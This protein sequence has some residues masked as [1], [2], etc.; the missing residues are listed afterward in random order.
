[1]CKREIRDEEVTFWGK[2]SLVCGIQ[3][4]EEDL[5]KSLIFQPVLRERERER[6]YFTCW[7][8]IMYFS[9]M[10]CFRRRSS[11]AS[12]SGAITSWNVRLMSGTSSNFNEM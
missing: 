5:L 12:S 6:E 9:S 2:K 4:S 1:M 3:V 11:S 8:R 7:K 10:V